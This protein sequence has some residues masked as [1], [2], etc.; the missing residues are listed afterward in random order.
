MPRQNLT[1][2]HYGY[3]FI[4]RLT[5]KTLINNSIKQGCYMFIHVSAPS[6]AHQPF[7][8]HIISV[9]ACP[10]QEL[11]K[12]T[13]CILDVIPCHVRISQFLFSLCQQPCHNMN[14]LLEFAPGY[15]LLNLR[16]G[17]FPD[18][19][20]FCLVQ[21][22][23]ARLAA[24]LRRKNVGVIVCYGGIGRHGKQMQ[25]GRASCRERV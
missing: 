8:A 12:I 10:G 17:I 1:A 24:I 16:P 9:P 25:I 5:R 21:L 15:H 2:I 22:L 13:L 3:S 11:L 14:R 6:C 4:F 7:P 19:Q 23:A 20:K 18:I